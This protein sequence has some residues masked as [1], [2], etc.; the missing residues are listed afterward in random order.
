MR[1]V[2]ILTDFPTQ[3]FCKALNTLSYNIKIYTLF[4]KSDIRNSDFYAQNFNIYS[5]NKNDDKRNKW[6]FFSRLY[7]LFKKRKNFSD[8]VCICGWD[9]L[10]YWF[11]LFFIKPKFVIFNLESTII[12]SKHHGLSGFLKKQLFK[13]INFVIVPGQR[14]KDLALKLGFNKHIFFLNGVGFHT[15]YG[16]QYVRQKNQKNSYRNILYVGRLSHEKG[17]NMILEVA[18]LLPDYNFE[19]IGTGPDLEVINEKIKN[20]ALININIV[21]YVK[22]VDLEKYYINN[23]ILILPSLSEVW[24]LVIEEAAHFQ[25]PV[26][27]SNIVGCVDDFILKHNI[28]LVFKNNNVL[29][30]KEKIEEMSKKEIYNNFASNFTKINLYDENPFEIAFNNIIRMCV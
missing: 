25:I 11:L 20:N 27:V 2:T 9:Y 23:D 19:I 6:L 29:D 24:G 22:N 26:I 28:G 15:W 12:E 13:K 7:N 18:K 8:I 4:E 14:Q 30:F 17:T 3:Y 16:N 10:E 21:G 1:K 5:I